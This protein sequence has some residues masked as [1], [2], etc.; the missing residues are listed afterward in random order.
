[1]SNPRVLCA[2]LVGV[3]AAVLL[4]ACGSGSSGA[5]T[6]PND[7][8]SVPDSARWV[9]PGG[10]DSA[11]GTKDKPW[12]T[13]SGALERMTDGGT[14]VV[15][16]GTYDERIT[17]ATPATAAR[18]ILV[19]S[20]PNSQPI[21]RPANSDATIEVASGAAFI[22]FEG[23]T[24]EGATGESS[25]NIYVSGTA[26]DITFR[27]CASRGSAR[28]GFFSERTTTNVRV[29]NCSFS[30]NGGS[31]P[32]NQDH[33]LY[34]EG[35]GHV[36]VNNVIV[37]ARNGYGVQVYPVAT[38]V[39]VA[40]N[41]IVGNRNGVVVGADEKGV[42]TGVQVANNI[43]AFNAQIGISTYWGDGVA[44]AG[45]T[46]R[47]NVLHKNGQGDL[48]PSATGLRLVDNRTGDPRFANRAAGDY[49]LKQGSAAD[50]KAAADLAPRVDAEGHPRNTKTP[51]AGAYER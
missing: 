35:T 29:E 45:N 39:L 27:R 13:I 34:V 38:N 25:A 2:A 7:P 31:G 17:A 11:E 44:G 22:T 20:A 43:I 12:A 37:G 15:A 42:T 47:T 48:D 26:H 9:A 19:R 8:R 18:P 3:C 28:Q 16:A 32:E 46:A 10:S 24:F 51:D 50:G 4:A 23:L 30:K 41:T 14:V 33:N 5:S 21:I 49:H 36:I 6:N 40:N 1:M